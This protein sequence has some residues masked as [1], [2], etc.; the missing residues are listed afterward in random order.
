M[1]EDSKRLRL[2][3]MTLHVIETF[4]N[5]VDYVNKLFASRRESWILKAL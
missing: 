3:Y 5:A 1:T 2:S 4:I